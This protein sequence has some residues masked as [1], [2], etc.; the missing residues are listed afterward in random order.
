[1]R[2]YNTANAMIVRWVDIR[3]CDNLTQKRLITLLFAVMTSNRWKG[4]YKV[5]HD[6]THDLLHASDERVRASQRVANY[7]RLIVDRLSPLI[8]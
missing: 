6:I 4:A 3:K 2:N 5:S 7:I 8:I 1:M